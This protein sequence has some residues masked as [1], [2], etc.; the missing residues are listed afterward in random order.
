MK[1]QPDDVLIDTMLAKIEQQ[2]QS[3]QWQKD[4]GEF[5]EHPSTWLNQRRWED[6]VVS[7]ERRGC[8]MPIIVNGFSQP[9]GKST[10]AGKRRCVDHEAK[11]QD[12][13]HGDA[14]STTA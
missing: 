5:I 10:L 6:E 4:E 11:G 3:R 1:Y 14:Q 12:V 13:E 8:Q 9:C 7:S 2:K